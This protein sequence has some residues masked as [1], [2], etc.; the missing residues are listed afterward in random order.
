M[1]LLASMKV[2][3]QHKYAN[4]V[5]HRDFRLDACSKSARPGGCVTALNISV[6]ID[7]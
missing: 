6:F 4:I 1:S 7:F 2:S 3:G 5:C